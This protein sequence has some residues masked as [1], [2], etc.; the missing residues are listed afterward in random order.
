M[1]LTPRIHVEGPSRLVAY[2]FGAHLAEWTVDGL[3]VVWLSEAAVL[4][5]SRPIRGGVPVCYPWFADGPDGG[6]SPSHGVVRTSTW[7]PVDPE[8]D[9]VWAWAVGGQDVLGSPGAEHV[10]GDFDLRYAVSLADGE[11]GPVMDLSLRVHN[12]TTEDQVVEVALHTY[13]HVGDVREIA[14]LGLEEAPYLD[15][16]T[17]RH[18]V[19]DGPL[20]LAGE[21]DRVYDRSGPVV[22]ED[23]ASLRALHVLP[24]GAAQTVVWNPWQDKAA[25]LEDLGDEEWLRF[26]CVETVARG[27]RALVVAAGATARIGV[28]VVPT[29]LADDPG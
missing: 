19:Q 8:P 18:E 22:V 3:P 26:V 1:T 20:Q 12:P 9:E 5:G 28:R 27:D 25:G 4:D 10:P 15:K 24:R 6:L 14:V 7:S 21:T 13:L 23:R 11:P 29:T 2:D 17:G 16:V